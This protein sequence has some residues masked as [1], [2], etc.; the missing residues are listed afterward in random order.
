[1]DQRP[2]SQPSGATYVEA[3]QNTSLC[4]R[5]TDLAGAAV[6][7]D[8]LGRPRPI[9]GNFASVFSL[10]AV[11]G[12]RYA[13]KCFTREVQ[14]QAVRYR[15]IS[16]HLARSTYDWVVRF[17][18]VE[19][20]ILVEGHWFAILRME[21]VEAVNL[22]R[23]VERNLGDPAALARAGERFGR[24][25]TE[26]AEAGIGHGDLQ[27]GNLLVTPD[28]SMRL[29][30]YDGMYVPALAGMAAAEMGHRNYQSPGRS[31][32]QFGPTIDRF[33][34]WVIY[35]SLLG[36]AADPSLWARLR[37]QDAEHLLLAEADFADP[38]ASLRLGALLSHPNPQLREVAERF[39]QV[40]VRQPDSPPGL[41][42]ALG[43][44][45]TAPLPQSAP[46]PEGTGGLP[47]WIAG[48]LRQ[49]NPV[50]LPPVTFSHR[51]P[52]VLRWTL[53]AVLLAWVL[54]VVSAA[55][56]PAVA[57]GGALLTALASAGVALVA[58][59][60]QPE[61]ARARTARAEYN[62]AK[63]AESTAARVHGEVDDR[64]RQVVRSAG[65]A[66]A[67][68]DRERANLQL[69]HDRALAAVQRATQRAVAK[70]ELDVRSLTSEHG[71]A[72][73]ALLTTK[74][75]EHTRS[76]LARFT[77]K[78]AGVDGIGTTLVAN[79]RSHGISTAADFLEVEYSTNGQYQSRIARFVLTSG[80]RVRVP[81]VGEVKA[82]RLDSWRLSLAHNAMRTQPTALTPHDGQ[83]LK[84]RFEQRA[85]ALKA[86][87]ARAHESE[88]VRRL[89]LRKTL[90]DQQSAL[91]NTVRA[92]DMAAARA[93]AAHERELSESKIA[94]E[95]AQRELLDAATLVGS[96]KDITYQRYLRLVLTGTK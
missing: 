34:A 38:D 28:G 49:A 42:L 39:R 14:S 68:H 11:D 73:R 90:V 43:S 27:H 25:V 30:D 48:H 4:F 92:A 87:Q 94:F 66:K 67:D 76:Y 95:R 29:V 20:G 19:R 47:P 33:S 86:E 45:V 41:P 12:V 60:R 69:E 5:G 77:I 16:E 88:R 51:Y 58:Y 53:P 3:L 37:D 83:V 74:Q 2:R 54:L 75:Q 78:S 52:G 40:L 71:L 15:A 26:L 93:R 17:D 64:T 65:T 1:M 31:T 24:L 56:V 79:L 22:A 9:S 55:V 36:V 82:G 84:N 18:Y 62:R 44:A 96:Y 72:E 63:W 21:W 10:T 35:L 61:T 23:W 80:S 50:V 85:V 91:A 7:T 57:V 6:T 70:V 32:T 46:R 59:L 13:V 81:G 89:E 8:S